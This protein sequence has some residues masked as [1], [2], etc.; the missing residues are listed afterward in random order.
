MNYFI[1]GI[2]G[3]RKEYSGGETSEKLPE[4]RVFH[5]GDYSPVEQRGLVSSARN[6]LTMTAMRCGI[7]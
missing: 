1:E 7:R 2:Q 6:A 3:G 4:Y 5:E